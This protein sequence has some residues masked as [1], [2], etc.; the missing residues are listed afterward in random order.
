MPRARRRQAGRTGNF[1]V[2][3]DGE[4]A[5]IFLCGQEVREGLTQNRRRRQ[6]GAML[7][8]K[9]ETW[10]PESDLAGLCSQLCPA[11]AV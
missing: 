8:K 3:T 11:L 1:K 10:P 2:L 5:E 4:Q 7:K 9:K 6:D